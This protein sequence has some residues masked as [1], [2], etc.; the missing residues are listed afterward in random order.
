MAPYL[1]PDKH[2]ASLPIAWPAMEAVIIAR[3]SDDEDFSK[4]WP[5]PVTVLTRCAD[6][7]FNT[8]RQ[9]DFLPNTQKVHMPEYPGILPWIF[10]EKYTR[11]IGVAPSSCRL[12]VGRS[13]K[14][15]WIQTSNVE[16]K[17]CK[18]PARCLMGFDVSSPS[19]SGTPTAP[20]EKSISWQAQGGGDLH[21]CESQL[22]ARRCDMGEI[23]RKKYAVHTADIEDVL[24]RIAVGDTH[25]KIEVLDYA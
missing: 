6:D 13:G 12:T 25:G 24:G 17:H 2:V 3:W 10:P 11:T 4:A 21:L 18:Y 5:G 8:L 20:E 15:F 14:G 16:S 1:S 9:Y 7:G 23:L 22:Y 19:P